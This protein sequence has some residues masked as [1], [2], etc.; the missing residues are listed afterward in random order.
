M[1]AARIAP[2]PSPEPAPFGQHARV[3]AFARTA[4]RERRGAA[5]APAA[6]FAWVCTP[7]GSGRGYALDVS[8]GGARIAGSGIRATPGTRVLVKLV[9]DAGPPAVLPARVVRDVGGVLGVAFVADACAPDDIARVTA[10]VAAH[11]R[12]PAPAPR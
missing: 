2:V 8:S 10:C 6:L 1:V 3:L 12:V 4:P 9:C 7:D 11:A 5:R